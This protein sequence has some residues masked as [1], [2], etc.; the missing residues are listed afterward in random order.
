M[1]LDMPPMPTD[2][3]VFGFW[4]VP[5][6]VCAEVCYQSIVSGYRRLDCACDY[7]NEVEVGQGIVRAI[8]EGVCSREDLFITSKLWNTYHKPEHVSLALKRTLEELQLSY[9][10]EYLIHF[11]ISMEFVP[12]EKKYPPEWTNLDGKMVLVPNDMGATW[13]AM[14]ELVDHGLTKTIG[15]CNFSTQ[16]LRQIFSTCRIRPSTLQ[17]ELH[18]ENSQEKLIRFAH[19]SGMKVTAFS[20]LAAASYIELNMA[21]DS[22]VL[23]KQNVLTD[24]ASSKGKTPAQVL[25]RWAVQRNT[26]PITKTCK[27]ERMKENRNVMDFELTEEEMATING[28]NRNRRYNDPGDFCEPGMGTFCPIYD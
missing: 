15:V 14:E 7:G 24:I 6:D 22:D 17:V 8:K 3:L 10:D 23:M 26:F 21:T 12:F 5:K 11:P 28:L 18:P 2:P 9:L 25:I 20:T 4:K 1:K 16:L 13:K 19:E 27:V